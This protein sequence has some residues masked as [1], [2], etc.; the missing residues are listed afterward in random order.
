MAPNGARY[1][2]DTMPGGP[3]KGGALRDYLV[4]GSGGRTLS[5]A[6]R[7]KCSG[8]PAVALSCRQESEQNT[9]TATAATGGQ[10]EVEPIKS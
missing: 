6:L 3:G 5:R 9:R 8:V 1:P 10:E 2:A 4:V 7:R